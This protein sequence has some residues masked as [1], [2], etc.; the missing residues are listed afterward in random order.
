MEIGNEI[1]WLF[2][3]DLE[4][5]RKQV[6]MV[7][8]DD[9]LWTV[10]PG[11]TNSVGNLALHL[12][13][14]L[15]EFVGRQLGQVAYQRTRPVEFSQKGLTKD[16]VIERISQLGQLIPSVIESLTPEQIESEFPEVVLDAPMTTRQFLIHLYGHL[17]WHLGQ[18]DYLRRISAAS[19]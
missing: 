10:Q 14:N 2:R 6:E 5:L 19:A 4:R 3:R 13:G 18:I 7:A 17:N 16:A 9:A 11:V 12:E 1:A 8:D 15:R